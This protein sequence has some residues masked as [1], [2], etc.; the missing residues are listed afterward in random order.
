MSK[1]RILTNQQRKLL[2]MQQAGSD[3]HA[4][5]A[6]IGVCVGTVRLKRAALRKGIAK[7]A[8]SD[9]GALRADGGDNLTRDLFAQGGAA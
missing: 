7:G 8:Y 2:E 4:I 3:D 6:A 1:Q 5:A 9:I